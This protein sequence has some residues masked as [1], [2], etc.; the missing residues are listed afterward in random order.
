[1]ETSVTV[2]GTY[3]HH[4]GKL[5]TVLAVAR[6]EANPEEQ[7]VVYRAEY[8]SPDFG[9]GQV[10]IRKLERFLETIE[11]DGKETSRFVHVP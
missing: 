7:V 4:K 9:V 5:Y 11:V 1:M 3:K 10:W 6:N 8:E 2:G